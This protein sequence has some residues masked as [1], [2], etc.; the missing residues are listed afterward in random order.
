MSIADT[1]EKAT[2]LLWKHSRQIQQATWNQIEYAEL[3]LGFLYLQ[4][5]QGDLKIED[6]LMLAGKFADRRNYRIDCSV[7]FLLLQEIHDDGFK[8]IALK[9]RV[10]ETFEPMVKLASYYLLKLPAIES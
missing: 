9:E 1:V 5:E 6:L 7:F 3:Y 8:I 2:L 10:R 4:F